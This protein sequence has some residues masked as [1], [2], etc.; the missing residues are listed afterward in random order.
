[1][2]SLKHVRLNK[3]VKLT[4]NKLIEFLTLN[5]QL[6]QLEIS[7]DYVSTSALEHIARCLPNLLLL[8]ISDYLCD[9]KFTN[10]QIYENIMYCSQLRRLINFELLVN[11]NS[12]SPEIVINMFAEND[13]PIKS[14]LVTVFENVGRCNN[15]LI[16]KTLE[17]FV[18]YN[19]D[20]KNI[21]ELLINLVKIQPALKTISVRQDS[22]IPFEIRCMLAQNLSQ[23]KYKID[24]AKI[25]LKNDKSIVSSCRYRKKIIRFHDGEINLTENI[26]STKSEWSEFD[27]LDGGYIFIF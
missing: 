19:L 1:M 18:I 14:L 11:K 12:I 22:S 17:Y 23:L 24:E 4:E 2:P 26:L 7:G 9:K 5:P 15:M 8:R 13:V 21:D 6:Q 16:L 10:R 27:T 25:Y 20:C 3:N